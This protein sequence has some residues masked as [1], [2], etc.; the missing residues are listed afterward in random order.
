MERNILHIDLKEWIQ[1]YQPELT[2]SKIM[3]IRNILDELHINEEDEIVIVGD[4]GIW[5]H[6]F[7][8]LLSKSLN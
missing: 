8:W 4:Y 2:Q 5:G 6:F 3:L 7:N 1:N